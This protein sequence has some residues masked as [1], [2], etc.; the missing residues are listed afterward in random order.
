[1]IKQIVLSEEEF[2]EVQNRLLRYAEMEKQL[3]E[4]INIKKEYEDFKNEV[5][6]MFLDDDGSFSYYI[7]TSR[8][9]P[10]YINLNTLK[11]LDM[12]EELLEE[13]FSKETN[14]DLYDGHWK[15]R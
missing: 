3:N 10:N 1:M 8:H 7:T 5:T 11:V 15:V 2:E 13:R 9:S 4:L 14:I 12:F 6:A